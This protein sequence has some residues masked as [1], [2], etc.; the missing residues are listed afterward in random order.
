MPHTSDTLTK[1]E[2]QFAEIVFDLAQMAA[3]KRDAFP[4]DSR[5]EAQTIIS[6]AVEFRDTV[7]RP[8]DDDFNYM[9]AV[10]AFFHR[11]LSQTT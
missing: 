5:A 3:S 7:D 8:S 6:W 2:Y 11:K 4:A 9:D 1:A 10:E